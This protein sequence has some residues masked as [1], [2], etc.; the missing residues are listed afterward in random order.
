MFFIEEKG[1]S[2]LLKYSSQSSTINEIQEV[3]TA[4]IVN[5]LLF[6]DDQM[7]FIKA[8]K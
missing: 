4:P 1:L 8:C 2:C 3:S 6:A 5:H 7:L